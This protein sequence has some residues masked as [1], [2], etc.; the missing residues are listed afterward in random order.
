MC[1]FDS[2]RPLHHRMNI[3]TMLQPSQFYEEIEK[4]VRETKCDYLEAVMIYH[5]R[6]GIEIEVLASLVKQHAVLKAKMQ[7]DCEDLNLIEK[8]ARLPL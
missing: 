1:G 4:L 2:R 6:T 7:L 8:T 5:E 3:K